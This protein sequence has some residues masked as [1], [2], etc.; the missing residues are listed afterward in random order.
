MVSAEAA[1][2]LLDSRGSP[3]L[4]SSKG[5]GSRSLG[6]AGPGEKDE[7]V[8]WESA[9]LPGRLRAEQIHRH[10]AVTEHLPR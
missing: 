8:L 6:I 9:E 4:E 3:R 10:P 7:R 2:Y 5:P 1:L